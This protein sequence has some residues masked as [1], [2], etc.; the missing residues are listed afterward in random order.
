[1]NLFGI[2]KLMDKETKI[3]EFYAVLCTLNKNF[4]E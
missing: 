1:M 4:Y 2:S 3:D